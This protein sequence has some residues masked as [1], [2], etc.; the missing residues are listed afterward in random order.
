MIL[1]AI[2]GGIKAVADFLSNLFSIN[3]LKEAAPS[4]IAL[5]LV[6]VCIKISYDNLEE[7]EGWEILSKIYKVLLWIFIPISFAFYYDLYALDVNKNC[8]GW[9]G[10]YVPSYIL[11]ILVSYAIITGLFVI[12]NHTRSSFITSTCCV[13]QVIAIISVYLISANVCVNSYASGVA[14]EFADDEAIQYV[15]IQPTKARYPSYLTLKSPGEKFVPTFLPLKLVA[16]KLKEGDIVYS[17]EDSVSQEK[18]LVS[19]GERSGYVDVSYLKKCEKQFQYTLVVNN[20]E[21]KAPLY[22]KAYWSTHFWQQSL[23]SKV[24]Q[25]LEPGEFVQKIDSGGGVSHSLDYIEVETESGVKGYLPSRYVDVIK[26]PVA[27]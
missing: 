6:F 10:R 27:S 24:I 15:V 7:K 22:E 25:Y 11:A 12:I 14:K 1:L 21:E 5:V 26:T 17:S 23:S 3:T 18:I 16:A 4:I 13:L 19:D 9:M 20:R 2:I 8:F